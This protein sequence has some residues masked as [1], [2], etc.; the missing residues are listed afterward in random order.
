MALRAYHRPLARLRQSIAEGGPFEQRRTEQ[1][2][3]E[4]VA[5]ARVLQPLIAPE[6]HASLEVAFLSGERF[7]WQTLFCVASLQMYA[8]IRIAPVIYD[9][10][11]FDEGTWS[12]FCRVVPWARLVR[13]DDIQAS[14]D[15]H[16]PTG[17]F[18]ALRSR[19]LSY[20]H[21]RKLTDIHVGR[22]GWLAVL[23]SDMLF[24]RAPDALLDWLGAPD[25]PCCLVEGISAY[26]YSRELMRELAG[27]EPPARVNV[28]ICGLKSD[29]ID[30]DRLEHWCREMVDREG[31]HYFQE[32]AL[33]AML[34]TG[35]EC[36]RFDPADYLVFPSL[37][38]G[39]VP[40]A[41][42]HHYVASSKRSYFQHGW[43]RVLKG[44]KAG[45]HLQP[46]PIGFR[47]G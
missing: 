5:A 26:G 25:R 15:R 7:W 39:R 32:Q 33:S 36:R 34:L 23:D 4:M 20:P 18:P 14:L 42:L 13:G 47:T 3:R 46:T 1:A 37:A 17:R 2:R 19:R 44:L 43:R 24:F 11:T 6:G 38:E 9:D 10:G 16:L 29:A 8:P 35:Q 28:G 12:S 27:G 41:A 40:T 45:Q 31:P 21:L 30:W 22:R